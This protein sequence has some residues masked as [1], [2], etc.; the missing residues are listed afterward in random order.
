MNRKDSVDHIS[1]ATWV[2]DMTAEN[3]DLPSCWSRGR[4][5]A[6]DILQTSKIPSTSY[7]FDSFSLASGMDLLC[8]F[9]GGRYPSIDDAEDNEEVEFLLSS[10]VAPTVQTATSEHTHTSDGGPG[11]IQGE[12]DTGGSEGELDNDLD[13]DFDEAVEDELNAIDRDAPVSAPHPTASASPVAPPSGPGVCTEDYLW[14]DECK[15]IHKQSVCQLVITPDFTPKL[16]TRLL[17]V[18]GYTQ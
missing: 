5:K 13:I 1:R 7:N 14:C 4:Q 2:G 11:P 8:I 3:C 6:L 16:T 10:R 12:V 18:R 17:R 15:W 9:G